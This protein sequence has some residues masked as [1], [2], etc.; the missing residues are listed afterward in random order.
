MKYNEALKYKNESVKKADH[1]VLENYHIV[2][3]PADTDE[4]ARY[5]ADY[6]KEPDQFKD[7]SCKEYCSNGEFEVV[8]F[9]KEPEAE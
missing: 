8:S 3:V 4:S 2:I 6:S 1:S 5:I 9:R 7:S